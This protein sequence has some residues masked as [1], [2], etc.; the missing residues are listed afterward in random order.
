MNAKG[1][2]A[3][4]RNQFWAL[5][6]TSIRHFYYVRYPGSEV[7]FYEWLR[8]V[9]FRPGSKHYSERIT[10]TPWHTGKDS[11]HAHCT[12]LLPFFMQHYKH[13]KVCPASALNI[14]KLCKL[15]STVLTSCGDIWTTGFVYWFTSSYYQNNQTICVVLFNCFY[16]LYKCLENHKG[17]V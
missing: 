10:C 14:F 5:F 9:V 7:N 12:V 4:A 15:L 6:L 17:P 1:L 16:N 11:T 3:A 2:Y 13:C 8:Q